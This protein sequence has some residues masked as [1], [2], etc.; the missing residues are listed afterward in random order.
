MLHLFCI[1][2]NS[3]RGGTSIPV[4]AALWCQYP[5]NP[6]NSMSKFCGF[7]YTIHCLFTFLRNL[8]RCN[9]SNESSTVNSQLRKLVKI[10]Q[11]C[12]MKNIM[13]SCSYLRYGSRICADWLTTGVVAGIEDGISVM[14]GV[15]PAFD[16]G[17]Y[18]R[19]T[20]RLFPCRCWTLPCHLA[21]VSSFPTPKKLLTFVFNPLQKQQLHTC[22]K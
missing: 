9:S 15:S 10:S 19:P 3:S 4:A 7:T 20:R 1:H 8:S 17:L 21:I 13:Y 2:Y 16:V 18:P 12:K 11:R 22:R 6:P 5:Q 14:S